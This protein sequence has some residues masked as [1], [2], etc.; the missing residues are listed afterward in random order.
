LDA[1]KNGTA[2]DAD[3]QKMQTELQQFSDTQSTNAKGHHGHGHGHSHGSSIQTDIKSFLDEIKNGTATD[4]DLQK[5]QT[6][7]QQ[8]SDKQSATDS[9][10][11]TSGSDIRADLKSF[12]DEIKNGTATDADMLK[13]QTELNQIQI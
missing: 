3:L 10:Q 5:M 1:I 13:M 11:N 4:V 6:E 12:L 8:F 2:T 9:S 7:L